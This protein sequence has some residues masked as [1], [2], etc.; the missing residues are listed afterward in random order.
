MAVGDSFNSPDSV[1]APLNSNVEIHQLMTSVVP[2]KELLFWMNPLALKNWMEFRLH[3]A[4]KLI[5]TILC[6]PRMLQRTEAPIVDPPPP[7]SIQSLTNETEPRRPALQPSS[8]AEVS[9]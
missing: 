7:D 3:D 5:I 2:Y 4:P 9:K 1:E 8:M 6:T